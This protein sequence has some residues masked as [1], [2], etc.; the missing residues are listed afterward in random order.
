M[1]LSL[2]PLTQILAFGTKHHHP[3]TKNFYFMLT[4][5]GHP[6]PGPVPLEACGSHPEQK[7]MCG[8]GPAADRV[9]QTISPRRKGGECGKAGYTYNT[10]WFQIISTRRK[11]GRRSRKR[12]QPA[13]ASASDKPTAAEFNIQCPSPSTFAVCSLRQS[14]S[15]ACIT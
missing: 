11:Y 1:P 4:S 12:W 9:P 15:E 14:T 6:S 7:V 5:P 10:R 13:H 3:T 2:T 8:A